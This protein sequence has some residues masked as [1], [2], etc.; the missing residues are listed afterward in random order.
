M[1]MTSLHFLK[2]PLND[3]KEKQRV[4]EVKHQPPLQTNKDE[5]KESQSLDLLLELCRQG[6]VSKI[7]REKNIPLTEM[8][9]EE[10]SEDGEKFLSIPSPF[11]LSQGQIPLSPISPTL[12]PMPQISTISAIPDECFKLFDKLCSEMLVMDAEACITTTFTLESEAFANSPFYGAQ[13]TIEEYSTAPKVFNVSITAQAAAVTQV[14]NHMAGFF[15]LLET[16]NFSFAIHKID[17][18]LSTDSWYKDK[19]S[20]QDK[21]EKEDE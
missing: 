5:K 17:T 6:L 7:T 2:K 10:E 19:D 12:N 18:Y 21:Q 3:L 14:E 15:E 4:K 20:N 9:E 1:S 16:R 11:T 13:V 8:E